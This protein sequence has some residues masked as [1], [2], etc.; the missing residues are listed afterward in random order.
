MKNYKKVFS[1]NERAMKEIR[2]MVRLLEAE[3]PGFL[4]TDADRLDD[5]GTAEQQTTTPQEKAAQKTEE[6]KEVQKDS[7]VLRALLTRMGITDVSPTALAKAIKLGD[8]RTADQSKIAARVFFGMIT[9]LKSDPKAIQDF[10]TILRKFVAKTGTKT[11]DNKKTNPE[12][13]AGVSESVETLRK[14]FNVHSNE[15]R[16]ISESQ[17]R[18]MIRSRIVSSNRKSGQNVGKRI[19]SL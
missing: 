1:V 16:V 5:Q 4:K 9:L 2:R 17:I 7:Q 13:Y 6:T 12:A 15:G 14:F 18:N 8:K 10:M 19:S 11:P 3:K